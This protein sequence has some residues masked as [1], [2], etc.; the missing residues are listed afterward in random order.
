MTAHERER[1]DLQRTDLARMA[2]VEV[3]AAIRERRWTGMTHGASPGSLQANLAV[4]PERHAF[5]FLRFCLL[6]PSPCPVIEVTAPGSWEP[7]ISAP[8]GDLRQELSGFRVFRDGLLVE[9]VPDLLD[10]WTEEHVGFLLG[11]SLSFDYALDSSGIHMQH[12]HDP[13][14]DVQM[15][16]SN[17]RC[18]PSGP[19]YGP[20]VVSMRRIPRSLV[21]RAIEV[22]ARYPKAHGSPV[23]V[24]DPAAIGVDLPDWSADAST[25]PMFWGCGVTPQAVAIAAGLP[26]LF[27][28]SPGH[29]FVTDLGLDG[30]PRTTWNSG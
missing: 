25:V 29:M 5:H 24:G 11:C 17:L 20:M 2:P 8:G 21:A 10:L 15:F 18:H 26:E 16:E 27:T 6:N 3:R 12:L 22:T 28:H 7:T 1:A 30:V 4:V 14:T 13:E 23:H 9:E 19:F